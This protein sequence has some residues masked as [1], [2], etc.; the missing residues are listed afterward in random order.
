MFLIVSIF[1]V[2]WLCSKWEAATG[3]AEERTA[4]FRGLWKRIVENLVVVAIVVV[5]VASKRANYTDILW[6]KFCSGP[7]EFSSSSTLQNLQ[8]LQHKF[9]F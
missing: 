2:V 7:D 5:V 1:L 4:C 3:Q 8:K 9:G 6:V